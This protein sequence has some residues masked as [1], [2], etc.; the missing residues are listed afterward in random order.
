M[1]SRDPRI[2]VYI[3]KARPFAQPILKHL[4]KAVHAGCPDVEETVKWSMPA[5]SYKGPMAGMAAFKAHCTFTFWK[6]SLIEGVPNAAGAM[7]QFGRI[8]S[9]E[10]LPSERTLV[11]LVKAAAKLNDAGVKAPRAAKAAKAPVRV[12]P[13]LTAALAKNRRAQAAFDA[14]SPSHRREYVEWITE[15]KTAATRERRLATALAW[16]AE[17]KSRNWKYQRR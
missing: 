5:F 16:I 11:K 15:A 9:V 8:A 14:F 6:G 12:P 10:D 17:G 2:D 3:A 7:G 1:A 13:D 4:R